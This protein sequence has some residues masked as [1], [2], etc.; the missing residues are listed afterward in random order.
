M[1]QHFRLEGKN[2]FTW[3]FCSNLAVFAEMRKNFMTA[4]MF[5]K[6]ILNRYFE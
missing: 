2:M 3:R 4:K 1:Q 6:N 5:S